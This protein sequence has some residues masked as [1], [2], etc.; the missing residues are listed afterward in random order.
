MSISSAARRHTV[1]GL[2]VSRVAED[3]SVQ[4]GAVHIGHHTSNV[5]RRVRAFLLAV[6]VSLGELDRVQVRGRWG[7]EVARVALIERINL[8]T[9]GKSDRRVGQDE[10]AK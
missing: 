6:G 1:L 3:A 2:G 5:T 8:A 10:L 9:V 4:Q 7:M